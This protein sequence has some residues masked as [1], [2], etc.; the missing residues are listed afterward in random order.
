MF[1]APWAAPGLQQ[2]PYRRRARAR[3]SCRREGGTCTHANRARSWIARRGRG[4]NRQFS[5]SPWHPTGMQEEEKEH[6]SELSQSLIH[7]RKIRTR[8]KEGRKVAECSH[9]LLEKLP[10]HPV[11]LSTIFGRHPVQLECLLLIFWSRHPVQLSMFY[12]WYLKLNQELLMGK[13]ERI[14]KLVHIDWFCNN[15]ICCVGFYR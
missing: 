12:C 8:K 4:E 13:F 7:G 10:R 15:W 6:K 11:Q 5:L 1:A 2:V 3:W 9:Y 14:V